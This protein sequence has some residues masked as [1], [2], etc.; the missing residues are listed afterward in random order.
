MTT[1]LTP[2]GTSPRPDRAP[3]RALARS[4]LRL[5]RTALWSWLP[6]V[7][8]LP[9]ATLCGPAVAALAVTAAFVL[10]NRRTA[11]TGAAV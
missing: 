11:A 9:A 10:L 1:L 4:V 2:P 8:A 5:H 6:L 7:V 3:D